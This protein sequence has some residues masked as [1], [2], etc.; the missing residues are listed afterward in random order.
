MAMSCSPTAARAAGMERN[1]DWLHLNNAR[2]FIS[3]RTSG[4]YP[5]YRPGI[6]PFHAVTLASIDRASPRTSCWLLDARLGISNP[7]GQLPAYEWASATSIRRSM[8]GRRGASTKNRREHRGGEGDWGFLET[9]SFHKLMLKL[10]LW[11]STA[12]TSRAEIFSRRVSGP[13]I[14][15]Y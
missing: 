12:R 3:M 11:V 8:P 10:H 6:S 2:Q 15:A 9:A 7:N 14:S 5:W 13:T 4:E 1:A